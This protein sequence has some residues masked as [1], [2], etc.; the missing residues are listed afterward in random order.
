M[1]RLAVCKPA[2]YLLAL[3][4]AL[5]LTAVAVGSPPRGVM[6][7]PARAAAPD[8]VASKDGVNIVYTV[9]G[10]GQPTLVFVHGWAGNKSF[11]R[12]QLDEFSKSYKVVALDLAGHGESGAGRESYT[13]EAFADDVASVV[14]KVNPERAI[15]IGHSEGGRICVRAA[16]VL[17]SRVIGI[18]GVDSLQDLT[19]TYTADQVDRTLKPFKDDFKG[20]TTAFVK[21]LFSA[22]ADPALVERVAREMAAVSPAV[23]LSELRSEALYNIKAD[24]T[25][26]RL[27]IR[28]INSERFLTTVAENKAVCRTYEMIPMPGVG[29]FPML[30]D[31]AAFNQLLAGAI[32]DIAAK[33][34]P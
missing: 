16:R 29:H 10:A 18:I 2:L 31:P 12:Q 23:G 24:L 34:T 11:W 8:S 13:V 9:E 6:S 5:G 3:F 22:K 15:L 25:G 27:P 28:V 4:L 19:V 7:T 14:E 17:G 26:F 21:T 32:A 20:T 1:E 30:E 33:K